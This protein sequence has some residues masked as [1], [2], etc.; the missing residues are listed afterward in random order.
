[1]GSLVLAVDVIYG[2]VTPGA[3]APWLLRP[4][5]A[6]NQRP[7][8]ALTATAALYRLAADLVKP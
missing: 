4:P 1:M 6:K 3:G 7:V 2:L 5:E 8:G